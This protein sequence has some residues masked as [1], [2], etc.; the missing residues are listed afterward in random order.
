MKLCQRYNTYKT[1]AIVIVFC[2]FL[3][4]CGQTESQTDGIHVSVYYLNKDGDGLTTED[5]VCPKTEDMVQTLNHLFEKM[6]KNASDQEGYRA[7]PSGVQV[8][9][10]QIKEDRLSIFF[11]SSYND[12]SGLDELLSRAA[13]VKTVCQ[14]E[15]IKRVEFYVEDQPLMKNGIA[16]G[17]MKSGDFILDMDE[18]VSEQ[19]KQ[20]TLYFADKEGRH[21]CPLSSEVTYNTAEPLANI[22]IKKLIDGPSAVSGAD[23]SDMNA[24]VPKGT[25][26]N[27]LT[28]RDN[29]CYLDFSSDFTKIREDISSDVIL[30][31]IVNTLCELSNINKVQFSIDGEL[32]EKYGE[33]PEFHL[34]M[35]RN[36]DLI[37][38]ETDI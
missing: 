34:P 30:Y 23:T 12:L 11:S 29:I 37:L 31:S 17:L 38:S 33:T 9:N 3:S 36:L 27:S 35:E 4:S 15:G 32:Q 25:V 6:Q 16:V 5:T 14:A 18:G 26:L 10:F 28:I 24:S 8:R 13:I 1:I 7:I 20:V 22:L 2:I 19:R 21:L